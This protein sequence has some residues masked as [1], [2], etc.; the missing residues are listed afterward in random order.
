M[1]C[2]RIST[3]IWARGIEMKLLEAVQA[4]LVSAFRIPE[5]DRDV[6]IDL[7]DDRC[8]LLSPGRTERYTRVEIIGIAARSTDAKR[9]LFRAIV[10]NLEPLGVPR[11]NTRI[12]LMEPPAENWGI[13]GGRL[14]SEVD[15][16][17]KIDV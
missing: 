2:V 4:A 5:S 10:G 12:Y 11:D 3:G 17:F 16:G 14:A 8:R 7:Y 15:L 6:S 13:K 9:A 1:P